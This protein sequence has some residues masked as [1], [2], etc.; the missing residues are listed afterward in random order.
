MSLSWA[1]NSFNAYADDQRRTCT[2][3]QHSPDQV[4][5]NERLNNE[6]TDKCYCKKQ[7]DHNF[8]WSTLLQ[9]IEM[10]P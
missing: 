1:Q 3:L 7:I 2:Q 9:I 6:L 4:A 10:M 8:P 5:L